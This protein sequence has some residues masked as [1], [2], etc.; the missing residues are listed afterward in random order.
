[1]N[2]SMYFL[3]KNYGD[4]PAG[5]WLVLGANSYGIAV[6]VIPSAWEKH[7]PPRW[8]NICILRYVYL[9]LSGLASSQLSFLTKGPWS[10]RV[11]VGDEISCLGIILN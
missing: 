1:M 9:L 10:F 7:R 11:Y 2:E 6:C 4:F 5:H 3:L 8:F